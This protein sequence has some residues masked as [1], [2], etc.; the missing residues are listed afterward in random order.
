MKLCRGVSIDEATSYESGCLIVRCPVKVSGLK[1]SKSRSHGL[2]MD[3]RSAPFCN[4]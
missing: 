2:Q 1:D 4:A 3:A